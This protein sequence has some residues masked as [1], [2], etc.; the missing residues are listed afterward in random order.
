MKPPTKY[1]ALHDIKPDPLGYAFSHR[2]GDDVDPAVVE[3]LKLRVGVDVMPADPTVI[4]RPDEDADRMTWEAYAIGQGMPVESAQNAE[5]DELIM[6]FPAEENPQ[7]KSTVA[8][9][10]ARN[11][12]TEEWT[13]YVLKNYKDVKP[14]DLEGMGRDDLVAKYHPAEAGK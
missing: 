4:P 3:N 2:T 12:S 6:Q 8:L 11:A 13:K 7:P 9:P 14:E 1:T 5:R 10:P